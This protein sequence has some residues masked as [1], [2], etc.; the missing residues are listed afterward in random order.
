LQVAPACAGLT[1][2][3][4]RVAAAIITKVSFGIRPPWG[5]HPTQDPANFVLAAAIY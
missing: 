3:A 5:K 1:D 2:K 4:R